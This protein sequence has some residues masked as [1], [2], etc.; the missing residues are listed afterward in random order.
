MLITLFISC[1]STNKDLIGDSDRPFDPP[2]QDFNSTAEE[3]N[4]NETNGGD[5]AINLSVT[6]QGSTLQIEH[7][8]VPLP[9][10]IDFDEE[11]TTDVDIDDYFI[12]IIYSER[13]SDDCHFNLDYELDFMDAPS[14]N[15]LLTAQGDDVY[16][17]IE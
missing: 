6:V 17:D 2:I 15:Y 13:T 7:T 11:M 9:C 5:S 12:E 4:P 10:D 8:S 1:I 3:P 14:G 16:F